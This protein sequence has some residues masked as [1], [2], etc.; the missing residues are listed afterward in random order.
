MLFRNQQFY[1]NDISDPYQWQFLKFFLG[2]IFWIFFVILCLRDQ[3]FWFVVFL[4]QL[5]LPPHIKPSPSIVFTREYPDFS[6]VMQR[7]RRKIN[8]LKIKI[9]LTCPAVTVNVRL[10]GPFTTDNNIQ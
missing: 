9:F 10:A 2:G 4:N 6:E 3:L 5:T 8:R 7:F 1:R